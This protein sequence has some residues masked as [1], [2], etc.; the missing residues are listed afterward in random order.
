MSAAFVHLR[1]HTEY[2]L[3]DGIVRVKPLMKAV[4]ETGMPAVAMT[5]QSNLFA[6]VKF[7][8][9]AMAAGVKP[10]I[11][12]DVLLHNEKEPGQPD[13]LVLLCKDRVGYLNLSRL[14][15]RAY[16]EGQQLGRPMLQRDWL[17]GNTDGLIALS[18]GREGDVGLALLSGNIDVARTALARWKACF[19][20]SFY[21]E[22]QRTGRENEEDYLHAAVKLALEMDVP[23]VATNDVRFLTASE[24][25]AHEARVCINQGRVLDDPRRP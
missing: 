16:T 11:G 10:I 4:A 19:P 5:D 2:S 7:Y 22:L 1:L 8:T 6:M 21:L 9:A 13:R 14:I 18:A 20:G 24:F 23:V 12:A 3:V 15:S 17:A 25:E